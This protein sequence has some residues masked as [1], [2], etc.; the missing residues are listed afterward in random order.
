MTCRKGKA[1]APAKGWRFAEEKGFPPGF[2]VEARILTWFVPE[3]EELARRNGSSTFA[4]LNA[5]LGAGLTLMAIPR[6]STAQAP[7]QPDAS[8]GRRPAE[9]AVPDPTANRPRRRR[10]QPPAAPGRSTR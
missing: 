5:A 8:D 3:I 6:V 10:G 4:V 1:S 2:A 9:P 7:V